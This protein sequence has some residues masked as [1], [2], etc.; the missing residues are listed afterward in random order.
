M[1]NEFK[2][3][4]SECKKDNVYYLDPVESFKEFSELYTNVRK[5]E[6]RFYHDETLS[7][8]PVISKQHLLYNEWKMRENTLKMLKKYLDNRNDI[9]NILDLGCG[10]SWMS[11]RLSEI[12][13]KNIFAIDVNNEELK[14]AARVFKNENLIIIHGDIFN[15]DS[16]F[17][18]FDSIIISGVLSYFPNPKELIE[19]CI[20]LLKPNGELHLIDNL[21]YSSA[22]IQSAS[23]R[24]AIYFNELGY[25]E[26]S[27]HFFHL[28]E[29]LLN[30]FST[31]IV[32]KPNRIINKLKKIIGSIYS[33]ASWYCIR[34]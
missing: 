5:K 11:N 7:K 25:P 13:G 14:Q 26:M 30:N 20:T 9:V 16:S 27:K 1:L 3:K 15:L 28:N 2:V 32:Y 31:S 23:E 8:L 12:N 6:G 10:N 34:K 29:E 33:P 21:F 4:F 24:S 19:K 22:E 17:F 18:R